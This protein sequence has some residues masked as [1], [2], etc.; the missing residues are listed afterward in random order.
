MPLPRAI[1]EQARPSFGGAARARR[2]LARTSRSPGARTAARLR[3]AEREAENSA[4]LLGLA[5]ALPNSC[6]NAPT[7]R[8]PS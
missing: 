7:R 2:R 5:A 6:S 1:S 4:D 3:I 8:T